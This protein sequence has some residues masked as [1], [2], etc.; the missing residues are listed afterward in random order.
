MKK[1][2]LSE[3]EKRE[4]FDL[5]NKGQAIPE[6]YRFVLFGDEREVELIW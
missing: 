3:S 2:N 5:L 1:I 4:I 6:K